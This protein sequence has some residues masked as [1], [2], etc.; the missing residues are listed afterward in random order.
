MGRPGEGINNDDD[1]D[2]NDNDADNNDDDDDICGQ[3][4]ECSNTVVVDE[5]GAEFQCPQKSQP[6][7]FTK[8]AH[9][10]DCRWGTLLGHT[11]GSIWSGV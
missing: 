2:D 3:V 9:P 5:E 7:V 1:D 8:H 6:G 10:S 4:P 11:T